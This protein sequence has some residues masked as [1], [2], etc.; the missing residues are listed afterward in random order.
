MHEFRRRIYPGIRPILRDFRAILA[1][2]DL[3]R[4]A[5]RDGLH[6]AFRERLMLVVTDVN[7]C[8]YCSYVHA[9]E[10]L[11]AG[12][13]REQV[14]DLAAMF[15]GCPAHEA[16]ALLYAQH[17]AEVDGQPDPEVRRCVQQRYGEEQLEQI[18]TV[19]RM[20]RMGNLL[21][22]TAD[23]LLYRISFGRWGGR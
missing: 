14:E 16:P 22:N 7:G 13:P 6:P 5:M 20:I 4:S 2:R 15:D 17:W 12:I 11:A 10:A 3:I 18:E 8:R 19:L 9:R 21:G 1:R 23:Y